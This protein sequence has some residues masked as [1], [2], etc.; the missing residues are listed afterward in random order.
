MPAQIITTDDLR[1]FKTE[2]LDDIK[3]LLKTR[4]ETVNKSYLK[5]ADLM[6]ILKV[7]SGT[8][9]T[10]RING[11]LPYTKIGGIIFYDSDEMSKVMKENTFHNNF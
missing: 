2:L 10:M 8:L 7:S 1:E 9:Q 3:K 5:S 11:T 6:K 4:A